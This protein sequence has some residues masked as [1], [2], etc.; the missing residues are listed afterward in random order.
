MEMILQIFI[1]YIPLFFFSVLFYFAT[2]KIHY[3][4]RK[5][6]KIKIVK[7]YL[8][9][10]TIGLYMLSA[11]LVG[12]VDY[13]KW[14]PWMHESSFTALNFLIYSLILS[15]Y[16]F[17]ALLFR[18]IVQY[19]FPKTKVMT[20]F[21][22][23][24]SILGWFSFIYQFPYAIKGVLFGANNLRYLMNTEGFNI[25]PSSPLTTISV[26]VSYF[27]LFYILFFFVA[28][29]QKQNVFIRISLFTGSLS[30]I[31][32]GLTFAARDVFIFYILGFI[33]VFLLLSNLLT[34]LQV[35]KIK[36]MAKILILLTTIGILLISLDRSSSYSSFSRATVGYLSQ[37]PFVFSETVEVHKN[38]YP[39]EYF[40][41]V[42]MSPFKDKNDNEKYKRTEI[43]EWNFGT[44][45]KEFYL[46]G[47][48]FFLIIMTLLIVPFFY[49]KLRCSRKENFYRKIIIILFYFQFLSQGVFYFKMGSY[50]GNVYILLLVFFYF[51]TFFKYAKKNTFSRNNIQ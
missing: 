4:Y 3:R 28:I 8:P 16:L 35:N 29:I 44:F 34:K 21:M 6:N 43:Y 13:K 31:V 48:Y 25:L 27:Y 24:M 51:L 19:T 5:D 39:A 7:N 22:F 33:F 23:G 32:S 26:G 47:G 40:F 10:L 36:K 49:A 15:L 46:T 41:P 11:L 38:N 1:Y 20:F 12:F 9:A 14:Y 2:K 42:F 45:I 37:Q 30:Y 50:P 18:P 17:P